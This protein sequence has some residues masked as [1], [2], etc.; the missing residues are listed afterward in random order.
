MGQKDIKKIGKTA[1]FSKEA[2]AFLYYIL[3]FHGLK[4]VHVQQ[5]FK[6]EY[7]DKKTACCIQVN[8]V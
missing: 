2:R 4:I 5:N 1:N 6:S 7:L 8:T 3:G